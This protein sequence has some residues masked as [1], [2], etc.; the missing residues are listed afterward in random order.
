[1]GFAAWV[2]PTGCT[3]GPAV[4]AVDLQNQLADAYGPKEAFS[5]G[6]Y[7]CRRVGAPGSPW[8]VHAEGRAVDLGVLDHSG[9]LGYA[10]LRALEGLPDDVLQRV[11]WDRTTYDLASP[12]GRPYVG[13][14]PHIDHLH[15]ELSWPAARGIIPFQLLRDD[16]LE[17]EPMPMLIAAWRGAQWVV[18][19]DLSGKVGL[20]SSDDVR[21]LLAAGGGRVY[22]P[23]TLTEALMAKIPVRPML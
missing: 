21:A 5:L 20:A 1:M 10:I 23:A 18:S 12:R 4:G 16:D 14:S 2:A 13:R 9:D 7:N 15:I 3:G 22:V 19:P 17:D 11:I 8:S 6:I